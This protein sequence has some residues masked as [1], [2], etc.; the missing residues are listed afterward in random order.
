MQHAGV[1][2]FRLFQELSI[3][4][5]VFL[6]L[7]RPALLLEARD[8]DRRDFLIA[9]FFLR[10]AVALDAELEIRPR[11]QRRLMRLVRGVIE[12]PPGAVARIELAAGIPAPAAVEGARARPS[13]PRARPGP[14]ARAGPRR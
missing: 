7:F 1:G 12:R 2:I 6:M 14:R 4:L 3:N 9:R 13:P 8:V 5:R 10:R 11:E